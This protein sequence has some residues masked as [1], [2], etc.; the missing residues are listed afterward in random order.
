MQN[1]IPFL[2]LLG[3][4]TLGACTSGSTRPV[5]RSST[6]TYTTVPANVSTMSCEQLSSLHREV[7]GKLADYVADVYQ[8]SWDSKGAQRRLQMEGTRDKALDVLR[9]LNNASWTCKDEVTR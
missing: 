3:V 8:S 5:L 7:A 6:E 9:A 4:L 2:A 1:R